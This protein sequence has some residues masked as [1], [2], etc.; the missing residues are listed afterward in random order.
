MPC[1]SK[2]DVR[3]VLVGAPRN[4]L[5]A[6]HEHDGAAELVAV[7]GEHQVVEVGQRHDQPHVVQLDE[8]TQRADVAEV[9]HGGHERPAIG[10]VERRRQLVEIGGDRGRPGLPERG[11]DVDA[12]ARAREE[13]RR[14]AG[15]V[16]RQDVKVKLR[17]P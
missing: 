14:H 17:R 8:V 12:L 16:A 2:N 1:C 10:V 4:R 5:G 11:D 13:D 7:L 15:S 6:G 9:V 3:Q